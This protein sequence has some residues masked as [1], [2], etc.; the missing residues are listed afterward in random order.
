M[1]CSFVIS[2]KIRKLHS[3]ATLFD[4]SWQL[5]SMTFKARLRELLKM[6]MRLDCE[7]WHA[8]SKCCLLV[9]LFGAFIFWRDSHW[10]DWRRSDIASNLLHSDKQKVAGEGDWQEKL[11]SLTVWDCYDS[12]SA[13]LAPAPVQQW[14]KILINF[15]LVTQLKG[16]RICVIK[17]QN[18]Q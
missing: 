18:E 2:V 17:I 12:D 7:V 11:L 16:W 1:I 6:K 13:G 9:F 5:P 14:N 10:N 15:Y 3:K 4:D 8:E